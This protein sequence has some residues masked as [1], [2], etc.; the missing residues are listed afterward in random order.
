MTVK[1]KDGQISPSGEMTIV[2][3]SSA[4]SADLEAL[5]AYLECGD[6]S[7]HCLLHI[8]P[9]PIS[10]ARD[11]GKKVVTTYRCDGVPLDGTTPDGAVIKTGCRRRVS[12]K[13]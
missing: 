3:S 10:P 2:A 5:K 4:E 1:L 9:I 12:S 7:A 8:F 6:C 13:R 11:L